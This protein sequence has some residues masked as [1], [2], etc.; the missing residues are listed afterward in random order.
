MGTGSIILMYFLDYLA[1]KK[2]QNSLTEYNIK[3]N[4]WIKK[5]LA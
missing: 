1:C 5:T 4:Y 3:N 2:M